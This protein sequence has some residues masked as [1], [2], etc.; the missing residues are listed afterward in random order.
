M[1]GLLMKKYHVAVLDKDADFVERVVSALKSLYHHRLVIKTYNNSRDMFEAINV[2]KAKKTPFDLTILGEKKIA[3]RLVLKQTDPE[4]KVLCCCDENCLR[5]QM[6][7]LT[8]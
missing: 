8:L 3:E 4:M 2:S 5:K 1:T 7:S 6:S